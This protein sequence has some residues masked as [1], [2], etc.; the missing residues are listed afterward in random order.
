M[1]RF[2]PCFSV[3]VCVQRELQSAPTPPVGSRHS[4]Q[5]TVK[6]HILPLVWD[7]LWERGS[8][9][10]SSWN[11]PWCC[12]TPCSAY[13]V[14]RPWVLIVA[15]TA[16][17]VCRPWVLIVALTH[18]RCRRWRNYTPDAGGH[19]QHVHHAQA[20]N[21]GTNTT[22]LRQGRHT[23]A[24]LCLVM[25]LILRLLCLVVSL[26]LCPLCL[27][28][29]LSPFL[30]FRCMV[31]RFCPHACFGTTQC[32]ALVICFGILLGVIILPTTRHASKSQA[33]N[34]P[35]GPAVYTVA[36]NNAGAGAG[37]GD[38]PAYYSTAVDTG[39]A[40]DGTTSV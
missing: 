36:A 33:A 20:T 12:T 30:G 17:R 2:N 15:L 10:S 28:T 19:Q 25:S 40:G 1:V 4:C 3:C 5:P 8:T 22:A 24:P 14:C 9:G 6:L 35:G 29:S 32:R 21:Y 38:D 31:S 13:R 23:C 39:S 27:V 37:A 18:T 34:D 11:L 7:F 16:Y 26:F